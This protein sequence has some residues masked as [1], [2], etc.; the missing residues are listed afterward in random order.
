MSNDDEHPYENS[1]YSTPRN[2]INFNYEYS[3]SN[4][5]LS[6]SSNRNTAIP[7]TNN[8]Q[9]IPNIFPVELEQRSTAQDTFGQK[10]IEPKITNIAGT[11]TTG[12][13]L[14]LRQV[15][16]LC[17][18]TI[19][20]N[21]ENNFAVMILKEPFATLNIFKTGEITVTGVKNKGDLRHAARKICKILIKNGF[22]DVKFKHLEI[23]NYSATYDFGFEIFLNK[24]S[25]ELPK[26]FKKSNCE[27]LIF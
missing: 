9:E 6:I 11:L 27:L 3:I 8:N 25:K 18:N 10:E 21:K 15:A 5:T 2:S 22:K 20:N 26:T 12:S 23:V 17:E 16:L 24:L 4:F 13:Q 7:Q 19:Y 14:D 1:Q